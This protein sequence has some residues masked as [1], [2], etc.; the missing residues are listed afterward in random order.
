MQALYP[1]YTTPLQATQHDAPRAR[2]HGRMR[3]SLYREGRAELLAAGNAVRLSDAARWIPVLAQGSPSMSSVLWADRERPGD[4]QMRA[5]G[6]KAGV[7][8][9]IARAHVYIDLSVLFASR[10]GLLISI[11]ECVCTECVRVTERT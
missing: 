10:A 8:G 9:S 4:G 1:R 3:Q 2:G 6:G 11:E 5:D 7:D